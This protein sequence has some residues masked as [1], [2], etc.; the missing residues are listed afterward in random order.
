MNAGKNI[1]TQLPKTQKEPTNECKRPEEEMQLGSTV[2]ESPGE[3][4]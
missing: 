1:K 2:Q 4:E 3:I